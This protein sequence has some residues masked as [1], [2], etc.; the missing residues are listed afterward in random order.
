MDGNCDGDIE[1][2]IAEIPS[3]ITEG[4]LEVYYND[5]MLGQADPVEHGIWIKDGK[6]TKVY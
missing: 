1:R 6:I 3:M 5:F 4:N 2:T